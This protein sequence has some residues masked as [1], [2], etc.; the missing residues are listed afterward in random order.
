MRKIIPVVAAGATVL[1]VAGSTFAYAAMNNDVVL[2]V[3][4]QARE[5]TTMSKTVG[6]VLAGQGIAPAAWHP[7]ADTLPDAD[8]KG[9]LRMLADQNVRE[10]TAMK[11][12]AAFLR[13]APVL[14]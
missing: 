10:A 9:F 14:Q 7:L 13:A 3:D 1:A 6:D 8:L 2:A 4:G 12:H 5:V 11:P